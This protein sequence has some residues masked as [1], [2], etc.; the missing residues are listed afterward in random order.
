[1]KRKLALWACLLM[2]SASFANTVKVREDDTI[3]KIAKRVGVSA[4]ELRKANPNVNERRLR[5][6]MKLSLPEE[7]KTA[8]SKTKN[9]VS[10]SGKHTVSGD[11]TGWDVANKYGISEA[12]LQR[13][14]PDVNFRRMRPGMTLNVPV[15]KSKKAEAKKIAKVTKAV[16]KPSFADP[17]LKTSHAQVKDGTAIL[18]KSSSTDSA[19]IATLRQG[20]VGKITGK[21]SGWYRL[22]FPSGTKG[23]V[24]GDLLLGTSAPVAKATKKPEPAKPIAK[25]AEPVLSPSDTPQGEEVVVT[26]VE[27]T[28][29]K[30]TVKAEKK[31]PE[32]KKTASKNTAGVI[33]YAKS[34]LGTRY[35]WGGT[36]RGGFDCSGFVGYVMRNAGVKLPRTSIEQSRVGSYVS[37]DELRAGDLVFFNTRG[38][39]ISHVGIFI[40]NGNF[41]HASSGSGRVIVSALSGSYYSKRYVTGRRV[42]NFEAVQ[43]LVEQVKDELEERGELPV[44]AD[45]PSNKVTPGVDEPIE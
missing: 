22:E 3:E 6:G 42:G 17:K 45:E 7:G 36:S 10:A 28:A 2:A 33:S 4:K 35:V 37:R 32:P 30:V 26:T 31:K 44:P 23:W 12:E 8:K 5:P 25:K 11:D 21:N 39:R 24:R 38:G 18:R 20:L 40:G 14:N 27:K 1:M 34:L 15:G 43:K 41:I 29:D 9:K 13:L 19:R 16:E